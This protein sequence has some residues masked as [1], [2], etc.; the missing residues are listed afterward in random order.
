MT[1]I[2]IIRAEVE[3]RKAEIMPNIQTDTNFCIS[4]LSRLLSFLDTLQEPERDVDLEKEIERCVVDEDMNYDA[5]CRHF[6]ELGQSKKY[7]KEQVDEIRK[8]LYQSGFDDG[9]RAGFN[10]KK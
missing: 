8:R 2:E 5:L 4:V 6:Y 1:T 3:R 7:T 9:Y 10:S